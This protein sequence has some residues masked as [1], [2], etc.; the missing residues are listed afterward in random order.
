MA[1]EFNCSDMGHDC[2][3]MVRSENEDELVQY[4]QQH[5]RDVHDTEMSEADARDAVKTT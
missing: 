4:V 1:Y 5:A 3:F 2:P